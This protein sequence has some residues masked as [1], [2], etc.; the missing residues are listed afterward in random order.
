MFAVLGDTC[1]AASNIT[2]FGL[3]NGGTQPQTILYGP[4][5]FYW[6]VG[7]ITDQIIRINPTNGSIKTY[8]TPSTPSHPYGLVAIGNT[9]WFTENGLNK[10]GMFFTNTV[11]GGKD[12]TFVEFPIHA[13]N[14]GSTPCG[15]AGMTLGP[16]GNLWFV[17]AQTNKI[18]VFSPVT[19]NMLNEFS[20]PFV[21]NFR[22]YYN[23][24]T[25]PDNNL[26]FTDTGGGRIC[27]MTTN[28]SVTVFALE[29]N[30]QPYDIIVGPDK[31]M[32]FSEFNLSRI[33]RLDTNC[34]AAVA[35]STNGQ[36]FTNGQVFTNSVVF[37][38]GFSEIAVPTNNNNSVSLTNA[39]PSGL[40]VVTNG[41][42]VNIWFTEFAGSAIDRLD[43]IPTTNGFTNILTRF[44]T[45]TINAQPT[46][47][48]SGAADTNIWFGESGNDTIG[49]LVLDHFLTLTVTNIPW[50]GTNFSGIL[51]TFTDD[52]TNGFP[53]NY[54]ATIDW[55][56][57]SNNVLLANSRTT[58]AFLNIFTNKG[59]GG[60]IVRGSHTYTDFS[61]F[62]VNLFI[63]NTGTNYSTGGATGSASF[64]ITTMPAPSLALDPVGSNK[65]ALSWTIANT[66][67]AIL[68]MTTNMAPPNWVNVT[69][70]PYLGPGYQF[71]VTNNKS[72]RAF[73]R[74]KVN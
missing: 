72:G 52:P 57:G 25:G 47:L 24:V 18:G 35:I 2:Q 50:I 58:N 6:T 8:T 26:W 29:T 5:N 63:T 39:Q 48:V 44:P 13:A 70:I 59:V 31:A 51:A 28:G 27:A 4:D 67:T 30:S 15:P 53:T 69:N 14:N 62:P 42:N 40:T 65:V 21:Q 38:N 55:G 73:Y 10:I 12:H 34:F 46:F 74:L 32:W 23:I 22:Q 11:T 7:F 54:S 19:T 16:D 3:P 60:F 17:E 71:T 61:V 66:N 33:G 43:R 36:I 45:P 49:R 68:Q 41:T 9:L 20:A 1:P 64:T 56:D 37:T